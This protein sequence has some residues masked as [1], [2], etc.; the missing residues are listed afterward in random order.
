MKKYDEKYSILVLVIK[1]HTLKWVL[2]IR[3]MYLNTILKVIFIKVKLYL[4]TSL[5][6]T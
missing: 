1:I 6:I 2:I 4:K 5:K 3:V